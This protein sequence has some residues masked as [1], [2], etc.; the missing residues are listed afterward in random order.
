MVH[1]IG[2]PRP[3]RRRIPRD[4]APES[5]GG[6]ATDAAHTGQ[7]LRRQRLGIETP[8]ATPFPLESERLKAILGKVALFAS[9]EVSL[10]VR[11]PDTRRG[12]RRRRRRPPPPVRR[13]GPVPRAQRMQTWSA[14]TPHLPAH[15]F[16][17]SARHHPDEP[18]PGDPPQ[19]VPRPAVAVSSPEAAPLPFLT[20]RDPPRAWGG[21]EPRRSRQAPAHPAPSPVAGV[22]PWR[23]LMHRSS[24]VR[25]DLLSLWKPLPTPRAPLPSPM[26]DKGRYAAA[27]RVIG[28]L[29][30]RPSPQAP[31][32]SSP[33]RGRYTRYA[34]IS[35]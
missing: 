35:G 10:E 26:A 12:H 5:P 4:R 8:R 19:P 9:L 14:T 32:P 28:G 11:G 20:P 27:K 6:S 31:L 18:P 16:M 29:D 3:H 7:V 34:Q 30:A 13:P 33:E 15:R 23:G 2:S 21:G 1:L 25:R 24:E 22:C 17:L